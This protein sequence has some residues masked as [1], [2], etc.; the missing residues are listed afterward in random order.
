MDILG[1]EDIMSDEGDIMSDWGGV[2]ITS[3]EG[4][5]DNVG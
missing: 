4:G 3:D 1:G 5:E 2:D